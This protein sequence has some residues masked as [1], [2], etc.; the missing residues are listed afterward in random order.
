[1][2]N[3]LMRKEV[4]EAIRAGEIAL[5]SLRAAKAKLDSAKKWGIFDMLGGGMISDMVKHSRMN[6]ASTLMVQ[7][8]SDVRRFQKELKDVQGYMD[9]RMEIGGFLSFADFFFD[10]IIADY[11]VQS[12]IENARTQVN[13]AINLVEGLLASMR[14]KRAE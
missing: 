14:S 3:E 8:R 6:E 11:M 5:G 9:L 13:D 7:A 10:G 2:G 12:K 1:M 4:D